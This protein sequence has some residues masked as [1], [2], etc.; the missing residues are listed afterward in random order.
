MLCGR[1][2]AVKGNCRATI[3]VRK[4]AR[5]AGDTPMAFRTTAITSSIFAGIIFM[6]CSVD[7]TIET[8]KTQKI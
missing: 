2:S 7:A 5:W 8:G 1:E 3:L 6:C 4:T